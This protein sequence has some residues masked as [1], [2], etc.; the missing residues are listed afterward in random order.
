MK[1]LLFSPTQQTSYKIALLIKEPAFQLAHLIKNYITPLNQL[2]VSAEDIVGLSLKYNDKGKCPAKLIKAH[3]DTVLQGCKKLGITTLLVADGSYFKTLT[4]LRTSEPHHGYIKPCAIVGYEN[5][6]IILSV[7]YQALF[8]NPVLQD[9]LTMSLTTLHNHI[10]GTHT[11]LGQDIIHSSAY[12]KDRLFIH[13]WLQALLKRPVLTC[14]IEAKSLDF[15]KAGIATIAFAWDKH[16]G[17]AISVDRGDDEYTKEQLK[18]FFKEYTGTLIYHNG[19]YDIKVLIYELFMKDLSDNAGILTGLDVM[20]KNI[21][22]TKIITYLATNTTAGNKLSLKHNA[23]EYTGNYAQDDI[24]NTLLIDLPELLKY[25]LIDCLATWYVFDKYYPVMVNDQ[26]LNIYNEIMLPSMKVITH[27]E[28]TGMPMNADII[29]VLH[30]QLGELIQKLK[31]ELQAAPIIKEYMWKR[32]CKTMAKAN[33]LLKKKVKPISDFKEDFNPAS[34][35]QLQELLYEH[36]EFPII[37]TTDTK[38]PATGGKTIKKL[39][40][41][42]IQEH[43]ITDEEL[44]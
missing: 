17:V 36:L 16:N 34:N 11:D 29:D 4:K 10:S 43:N 28:L 42:L 24:K 20:Y 37:D 30:K 5:I 1:H 25:N 3:L 38:L 9:R 40:N 27:M 39:L 44:L 14:D 21:H 41:K 7:N 26:Q 33:A 19:S 15:W 23:F 22:D 13:M 18:Q 31:T 12:P 6:N 32:Q 2:G 8:Y 35:T